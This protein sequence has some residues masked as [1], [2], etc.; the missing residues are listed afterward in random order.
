METKWELQI[1]SCKEIYL[2]I[3]IMSR[4]HGTTYHMNMQK[5]LRVNIVMCW[6]EYY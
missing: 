6:C 3:F 4:T 5:T 1:G 2:I